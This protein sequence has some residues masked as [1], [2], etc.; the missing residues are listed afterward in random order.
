VAGNHC[1]FGKNIL[2]FILNGQWFY[3]PH[4]IGPADNCMPCGRMAGHAPGAGLPS[5]NA[6]CLADNSRYDFR[7]AEAT[8][9]NGQDGASGRW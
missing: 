8:D 6:V 4:I 1:P 2:L 9:K 5:R 3:Q 7:L